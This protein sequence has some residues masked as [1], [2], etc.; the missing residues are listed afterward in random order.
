ME[1]RSLQFIADACAG[2]LSRGSPSTVISGVCTDSRRVQ[3]GDVFF[4]LTGERFDAHEFLAEV[5]KKAAAIVVARGRAPAFLAG[6]RCYKTAS[7][8]ASFA[9]S[10]AASTSSL[11]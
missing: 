3:T 5:V 6:R 2:E 10:S 11:A 1:P 8:T 9:D 4:A 7:L